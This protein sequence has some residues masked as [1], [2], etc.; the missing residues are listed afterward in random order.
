MNFCAF[1]RVT[2][3]EVGLSSTDI[4]SYVQALE[5]SGTEMH[6]IM[7]MRQCKVCAES[8][9][10]PY[11]QG[12]V[13]AMQSLTKTFT[14]TAYGAAEQLGI[15]DY[16]EY[17][18]DVFPEYAHL[19][20]GPYWGE[21]KVYHLLTMGSGME[22]QHP[23]KSEDWMQG[24]FTIPIKNKPG[25]TLYYNSSAC[26]LV[27]ACVKKRSG[28]D[29]LP[30]LK[31]HIF[32]HI[33]IDGNRVKWLTHPD[34]QVNGSGGIM[35]TTEDNLRLMQLYAQHGSW[36]GKQIISRRWADMA[37]QL[38]NRNDKRSGPNSALGY[39]GMMWVREN[40]CYA[41][42]GMGQYAIL[43]PEKDLIVA[44]TETISSMPSYRRVNEILYTLDQFAADG[45]LP[46]DDVHAKA[47]HDYLSRRTLPAPKDIGIR[48]K[49]HNKE[50]LQ[51]V[52]GEIPMFSEDL[53]I[54]N[55]NYH[56]PVS[57]ISFSQEGP[58]ITMIVHSASG[59][60]ALRTSTDGRRWYNHVKSNHLTTE[61]SL[62]SYWINETTL[63][64]E[65]R[66]IE[67]CRTRTVEFTFDAQGSDVVTK[68]LDVGGFD[69]PPS[70]A[71]ME[72]MK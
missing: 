16:D 70:K 52:S 7:I 24:F 60:N 29:A 33:G 1:P 58:V 9:W 10:A 36:N 27:G 25:T 23:I 68:Q 4:L 21:L 11:A 67:S 18:L 44:V 63:L 65:F 19:T 57:A 45:T 59:T 41:E 13:H 22:S 31:K 48:G 30:F 43:F 12:T 39:G 47:L 26:S 2:P 34:G 32:D 28:M 35:T 14:G 3:E 8:W 71:R 17:V 6:S 51:V 38:Q 55:P 49:L 15:L 62:F 72:I 50:T 5:S 40:A 56:E 54:F 66:W 46:V 69:V 37:V 53:D 20:S 61:L 42:G 64:M